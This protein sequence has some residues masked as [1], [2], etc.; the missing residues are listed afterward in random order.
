[1]NACSNSLM[2]LVIVL[3]VLLECYKSVQLLQTSVEMGGCT[4]SGSHV[5][6]KSLFCVQCLPFLLTDSICYISW[7]IVW[8]CSHIYIRWIQRGSFILQRW[9]YDFP[10]SHYS[11]SL[12]LF[13]YSPYSAKKFFILCVLLCCLPTQGNMSLSY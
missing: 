4:D 8:P 11:I 6:F 7:R 1:M 12:L 3:T 5:N 10:L 13:I 2:S 9:W